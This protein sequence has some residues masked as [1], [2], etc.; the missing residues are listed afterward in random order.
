[1]VTVNC[2]RYPADPGCPGADDEGLASGFDEF[3]G[4]G[5]QIVDLHGAG[6]LGDDRVQDP[7]AAVGALAGS[8]KPIG[9][10]GVSPGR[11]T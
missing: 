10:D 2:R 6:D 3:A 7:G 9:R 1:L 4:D 5:V 8:G 11:L